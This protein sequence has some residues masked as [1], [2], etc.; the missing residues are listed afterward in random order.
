MGITVPR[1][2]KLPSTSESSWH[3]HDV[4]RERRRRLKRAEG[5]SS[6]RWV[7]NEQD[8]ALGTAFRPWGFSPKQM[9]SC[10]EQLPQHHAW[11]Q[12]YKR[13]AGTVLLYL[14]V[15]AVT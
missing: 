4:S 13:G 2:R 15:T 6:W 8:G 9:A 3:S 14:H 7:G 10:M 1:V 11:E 5:I 12:P